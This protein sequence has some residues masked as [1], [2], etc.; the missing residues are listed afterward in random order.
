MDEKFQDRLVYNCDPKG[1][2]DVT[3]ILKILLHPRLLISI[4]EIIP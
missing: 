4:T 1:I 2:T 3:S